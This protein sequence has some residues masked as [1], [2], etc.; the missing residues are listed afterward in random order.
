MKLFLK[1]IFAFSTLAAL[2]PI[3]FRDGLFARCGIGY[4][5]LAPAF[6]YPAF[7]GS[8]R[9]YWRIAVFSLLAAV[10]SAFLMCI[11]S[12]I[13]HI[14]G[15]EGMAVFFLQFE[16]FIFSIIL[17]IITTAFCCRMEK[18][19]KTAIPGIIFSVY[20]IFGSCAVTLI[21]ETNIPYV[22][23]LSFGIAPLLLLLPLNIIMAICI[24]FF[25]ESKKRNPGIK[26]NGRDNPG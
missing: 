15:M 9:D 7:Y 14:S 5:M 20:V 24:L 17:I 11:S 8:K 16:I 25:S 3:F 2:L 23:F 26:N 22:I 18:T 1:C 21:A 12:G 6:F 4:C 10:I 13:N 19:L